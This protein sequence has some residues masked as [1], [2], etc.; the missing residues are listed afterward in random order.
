MPTAKIF[1]KF[2]K[3]KYFCI[4]GCLS[5]KQRIKKTVVQNSEK[6]NEPKRRHS[7][8]NLHDV[9]SHLNQWKEDIWSVVAG[10]SFVIISLTY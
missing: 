2:R 5:K 4:K 3:E 8:I 6:K 1:Q 9:A 7:E 10:S